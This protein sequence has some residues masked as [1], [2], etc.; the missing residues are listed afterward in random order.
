VQRLGVLDEN[1]TP[2]YPGVGEVFRRCAPMREYRRQASKLLFSGTWL[3]RKGIRQLVDAFA[4]LVKR[5]EILELGVLGGGVREERVLLDFP[6]EMRSKVR[7]LPPMSHSECAE[8]LLDYD[9]FIL[10]SWFE[11]TPLAL[12][13]AMATGMPVITTATCGMKDVVVNG[14]NGLLTSPGQAQQL[15]AAI[16]VLLREREL[17]VA[18]GRDAHVTACGYT[19]S[20]T[21]EVVAKTYGRLLVRDVTKCA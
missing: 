5:H 8:L 2:V 20:K 9:V 15:S 19:W 7:V 17:R 10:P 18:L 14:K 16:E 12:L 4:E 6:S 3:E 21:A 1:V 13:E 11:G